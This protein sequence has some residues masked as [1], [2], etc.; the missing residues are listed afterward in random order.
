MRKAWI[1]KRRTDCLRVLQRGPTLP[2]RIIPSVLNLLLHFDDDV[3]G[4]LPIEEEATLLR[5]DVGGVREAPPIAANH[6]KIA[7]ALPEVPDRM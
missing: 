2:D 5:E 4:L 1:S 6:G 7:A 3:R